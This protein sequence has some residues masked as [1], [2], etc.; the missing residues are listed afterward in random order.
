[1]H[2]VQ[3]THENGKGSESMSSARKGARYLILGLAVLASLTLAA[4]TFATQLSSAQ[5]AS[6]A[7][8]V[9]CRE[10]P[11][12]PIALASGQPATYTVRG[13]LCT[14]ASELRA[15]A[16]VQMLIHGGS[17]D[18]HYWDFGMV[19]GV[20]YSYARDVAAHGF[21]TFA[22]DE[23]GV[24]TSSKPTSTL[25]TIQAVA[26]VTHQIVQGLRDGSIAGVQFGKVISVGHSLGS[27]V[28][29][30]E[31]ISYAD[32]DGLIITG[33]AHSLAAQLVAASATDFY[34]A[35]ND[36]KFANSGLD[37]GYLTTVPGTRVT[38]FYSS[39]DYDPNVLAK[40]EA[41][42]DVVPGTELGTAL[43][44]VTSTATSVIQVP[45]LDILGSNDFT[46]C[47]PNTQG[48]TFDCSSGAAVAGQEAPFYAPSAQVQGCVIPGSGHSVS[49]S[50]NH[51]LQVADAVAWSNAYVGHTPGGASHDQ[52]PSNCS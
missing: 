24:G 39:P 11:G 42:K 17:Y 3:I 26:Y 18:H 20:T 34:P 37:T 51:E 49:L 38:L 1:M 10:V 33:A 6:S 21:P 30:Q 2:Q 19:D 41:D 23:I 4:P 31:A 44:I 13:E 32:I 43:P 22:F 8:D 36:P 46:T 29:W 40:D 48:G 15:G 52:L 50:L 16:T 7:T 28:V 27:V 25:L 5:S 35:V 14:T 9:T 45:V 12:I 47:G